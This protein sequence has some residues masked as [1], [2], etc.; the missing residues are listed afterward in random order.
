MKRFYMILAAL[1]IG[2]VCFAQNGNLRVAQKCDKQLLNTQRDTF[3]IY[4]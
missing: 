3:P 1:L 4:K 2:S